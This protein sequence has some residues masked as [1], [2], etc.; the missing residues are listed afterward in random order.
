MDRIRFT[1]IMPA[2]V[3]PVH[4]DGSIREDVLRRLVKDLCQTGITGIYA[5]GGTGE[6]IAMAPT[7][8]KEAIEI[9]KD[10]L[11]SDGDIKLINH[12]AA[13]DLATVKDLARHAR[14]VGVDGIAAV[15]PFFY[16]YDEDGVIGYY[17]AMSEA[18]EGLPMLIYASPLSGSPIPVSTVEKMLDIDGFCGMKYTNP[19]YYWMSQYKKID[20]GNI[21]I[22]NGPDET[23][24]LGL[25]MGADGAIGSTYNNMP[26]TF[27]ALYDAVKRADMQTALELQQKANRLI[28]IMLKYNVIA[29]VKA[30]L[31]MAG[32]EVGEP[33]R[34]L[35]RL[36][37]EQK[38]TFLTEMREAG[39]P[40]E[41]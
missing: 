34:P 8:R 21:N 9:I 3:T 27:V 31:E 18:A 11:P 40:D 37:P 10:A 2:L 38:Q 39:F 14:S 19:N 20:N 16:Q 29:C 13:A 6:G 23:C 25:Q 12:I 32:Y 41:Y 35:P 4:E 15:P 17:R 5:L 1:G 33:N 22:I 26:R 7:R 24:V 30:A 36:S 28:G